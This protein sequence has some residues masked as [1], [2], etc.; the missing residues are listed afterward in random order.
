[1]CII[2]IDYF[3]GG[4]FVSKKIYRSRDD[5]MLGGVCGGVANYFGIDSTIVRL[6]GIVLLFAEGFGVLLYII[7][8]VIIPEDLSIGG[9]NRRNRDGSIDVDGYSQNSDNTQNNNSENDFDNKKKFNK[10]RD[11]N[12][13][14][15]EKND[16]RQKTI[17]I[18][19]VALGSFFLINNWVPFFR[20]ERFW[21]LIFIGFGIV[22]ILKGVRDN[23]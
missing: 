5:R 4:M 10:D 15:T 16:K 23:E 2:K 13:D 20:W 3:K 9:K 6:I 11:L 1:M 17:G 12:P 8:W 21:P 14:D 18:I 19:L 7:S 22:L